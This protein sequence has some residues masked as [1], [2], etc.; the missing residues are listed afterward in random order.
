MGDGRLPKRAPSERDPCLCSATGPRAMGGGS[1]PPPSP[2]T[3]Q[4]GGP[5]AA[6][7]SSSSS[8][9]GSPT[10]C[11]GGS[12]PIRN[13]PDEPPVLLLPVAPLPRAQ[14]QSA[15][16]ETCPRLQRST[17][18]R[19]IYPRAACSG[20]E[21]AAAPLEPPQRPPGRSPSAPSPLWAAASPRGGFPGGCLASAAALR[22]GA[23]PC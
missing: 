12:R 19:K 20:R 18:R 9:T 22:P 1:P 2:G 4:D 15:R 5:P 11:C 8:L 17:P 10:P 7:R 14:E 21:A 23:P 3:P 13:P 6:A 16:A